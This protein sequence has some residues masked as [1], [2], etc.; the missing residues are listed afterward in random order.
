MKPLAQLQTQWP[1]VSKLLDEALDLPAAARANWLA[2]LGGDSADHRALLRDLLAMSAGIETDDFLAELPKLPLSALNEAAHLATPG[3]AG[4]LEAGGLVGPYRL[5]DQIGR[6][7]MATVWLAERDDGLVSR[8]VA[9]K[10]PRSVWGDSFAERLAH[11]RD[12]LA[13]LS[14]EHIARLYDVGIDSLGRPY[15]AMEFVEGEAIDAHCRTNG[16]PLSERIALLLQVMA[17]VAH[18]HARL[19]VHRD[20]KPSN[21]LVTRQG[22][23]RLL[24]FGIAKLLEGERTRE[25]ALTEIGGRALTI[26]YASPEQIRGEPIGTAS[27][28]YSMAVVAYEVLAGARPYRLKRASA[29]ELEEAI[30]TVEPPLAS[31]SAADP[32]IAR[33]LRGDLDA[34]LNKALKKESAQRYL[35]IEA[36]AEDLRR[37]LAQQPVLARPDRFVYRVRKFMARHRL[38]VAAATVAAF[39]LIGGAGVASWQALEARDQARVAQRQAQRADQVKNFVLSI[40]AD[41]DPDAGGGRTVSAGDLLRQARE[42]LADQPVSDPS[43]TVELFTTIGASLLGVG[44]YAPGLEVLEKAHALAE[45]KLSASDPNRGVAQFQLAQALM[46]NEK[47]ERAAPLLDAAEAAMRLRSDVRGI[48]SVLSAKADLQFRSGHQSQS[49]ATARE[50][51]RLGEAEGLATTGKDTLRNAYTMLSKAMLATGTKGRIEPSRRAYELARGTYG[52]RVT[53]ALL[54]ARFNYAFALAEERGAADGLVE[55]KGVLDQQVK[56]LGP[57]HN[58]A[59]VTQLN[60]GHIL[61]RT[62]DPRGAIERYREALRIALT[63]RDEPRNHNAAVAL[64]SLGR[65]LNNARRFAEAAVELKRAEAI[66]S[67]IN[68]KHPYLR[69]VHLG[70]TAAYLRTGRLSDAETV[71]APLLAAPARNPREAAM[72]Q[73]TLGEVRTS[74]AR[75]A[76]AQVALSQSV[77]LFEAQPPST[78][79]VFARAVS[80]LGAAQLEAGHVAEALGTLQRA[81]TM[82]EKLQPA[83]S[84]DLAETLVNVA[85]AE[86]ALN[87]VKGAV[88]A[89]GRAVEFWT[90]FD[91]TN[92]SAGVAMLWQARALNVAGEATKDREA[93][94]RASEILKKVGLPA[95]RSLLDQAQRERNVRL[96]ARS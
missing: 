55:M 42:R 84:P 43:V 17:A 72:T 94:Q 4:R 49:L 89:S 76:E 85:R 41:A 48:V 67:A 90:S 78:N 75:L 27:D 54:S 2:G 5:I 51:V 93:W 45:E 32:Q 53:D 69:L 83:V 20:L 86:L 56:L 92:R 23:V 8:R 35:S 40:F 70:L 81:I 59:Y 28:V 63:G 47:T 30:A 24:D 15:L 3:E 77:S 14:H 36:F 58:Q 74:Q 25:S 73:A 46:Y 60:I 79:P 34:I 38:Q 13:S 12:I 16:L 10:L 37:H 1:A 57:D 87:N 26:D 11:E 7:G 39:A 96:A 44:E 66:Y 68:P 64:G 50:A 33:Q 52:E 88:A 18:A 82:F 95:D 29:A 9:L 71:L 61:L 91:D 62:G 22:Q 65:A 6:G 31:T 80:S 21:I 19:V